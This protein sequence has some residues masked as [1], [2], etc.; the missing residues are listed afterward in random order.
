MKRTPM[1][2]A[3]GLASITLHPGLTHPDGRDGPDR[4]VPPVPPSAGTDP[5]VSF[6]AMRP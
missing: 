2:L 3:A 5:S 6:R 4:H 1:L